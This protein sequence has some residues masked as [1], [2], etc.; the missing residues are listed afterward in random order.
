VEEGAPGNLTLINELHALNMFVYEV[1]AA[2]FV[3]NMHDINEIQDIKV[4]AKVLTFIF[5]GST[6]LFS[7]VQEPNV[8]LKLYI[9]PTV[10]VA[11]KYTFC[12]FTQ[13]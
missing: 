13:L 12:K 8:V 3:G 5:D 6:M 2:A 4:D 9:D 7:W 10:P 11:G 1:H